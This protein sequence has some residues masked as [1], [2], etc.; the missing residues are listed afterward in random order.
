[1]THDPAI[2]SDTRP[3]EKIAGCR[4][5]ELGAI[6]AAVAVLAGAGA[7]ERLHWVVAGGPAG[8]VSVGLPLAILASARRW[9]PAR[10]MAG[11][12]CLAALGAVSMARAIDGLDG[13]PARLA[14]AGDEVV[15]RVRL[16]ADPE[17]RWTGASVPARLEA[18]GLGDGDL[19]ALERGPARG[20]CSWP[21]PERRRSGYGCWRRGSR[22][23]SW[24]GSGTWSPERSAGGGAMPGPPSMPVI[25]S[26]PAGRR[27]RCSGWPMGCGTGCWPGVT[28]SAGPTGPWWPASWSATTATFRHRWRPISGL[29]RGGTRHYLR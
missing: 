12:V 14:R 9:R 25:S 1:M 26:G 6:L 19:G 17:S 3:S 4:P 13:V 22:R 7:G 28:G 27:P 16:A 5:P 8:A 20:P 2:I 11:L 23:C 18:V 15:V 29:P 21:P 24:G 10:W